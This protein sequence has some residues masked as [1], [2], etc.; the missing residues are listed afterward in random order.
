MP[1]ASGLFRST[2]RGWVIRPVRTDGAD[3]GVG[4]TVAGGG[5][6]GHGF[7]WPCSVSRRV[8]QVL[9]TCTCLACKRAGQAPL[10]GLFCLSKCKRPHRVPPDH[11]AN[12]IRQKG[13]R[14]RPA[15]HVP[16]PG[17]SIA[18]DKPRNMLNTR[19]GGQGF[20][21]LDVGPGVA[22]QVCLL[23]LGSSR[24][25][26]R[27]GEGGPPGCAESRPQRRL[28]GGSRKVSFYRCLS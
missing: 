10:C 12:R 24:P 13:V 17:L 21:A 5:W 20:D 16:E 28:R 15:K 6:H 26:P 2:R 8:A 1:S 3:E 25:H 7:A 23:R 9:R 22:R 19:T 11:S 18:S 27:R 4:P 14:P